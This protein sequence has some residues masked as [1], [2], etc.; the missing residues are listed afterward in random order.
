MNIRQ[1]LAWAPMEKCRFSQSQRSLANNIRLVTALTSAT[2]QAS[3]Q[4]QEWYS[5]ISPG[6]AHDNVYLPVPPEA[7]AANGNKLNKSSKPKQVELAQRNRTNLYPLI[8][9]FME[10]GAWIKFV[11]TKWELVYDNN[12]G[13]PTQFRKTPAQKTTRNKPLMQ[14]PP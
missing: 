12:E 13:L 2:Q 5:R 3:A 6:R 8:Y 7:D 9:W 4:P 1:L 14:R 10:P 11:S